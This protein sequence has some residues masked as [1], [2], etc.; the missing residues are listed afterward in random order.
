MLR[1]QASKEVTTTTA[2]YFVLRRPRGLEKNNNSRAVHVLVLGPQREK[3]Q[4]WPILL[5]QTT[6]SKGR[7]R[8]R[9]L[10]PLGLKKKFAVF[11][12]AFLKGH[13]AK[14][15]LHILVVRIPI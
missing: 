11:W 9:R 3:A 14:I 5:K 13:K 12:L 15:T 10:F 1:Y 6:Q 4:N 8:R 7:K 2:S